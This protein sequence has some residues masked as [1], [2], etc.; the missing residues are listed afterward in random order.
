MIFHNEDIGEIIKLLFVIFGTDQGELVKRAQ[1]ERDAEAWLEPGYQ[2][3]S[4]T[5]LVDGIQVSRL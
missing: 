5:A 3:L 1:A 4:Q 2:I